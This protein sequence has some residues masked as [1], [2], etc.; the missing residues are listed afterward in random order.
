MNP[1]KM[2]LM[3]ACL[4]AG[5]HAFA[6]APSE[7]DASRGELLYSTHCVSCHTAQ[8]HW[9]DN[10]LATDWTSL[11]AQ[12]NRW[13]ANAGLGWRDA[14]IV[15]VARYLNEL[16]YHFPQTGDQVGTARERERPAVEARFE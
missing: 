2:A 14:D 3:T 15:A 1:S 5:A 12:V 10:R 9:R 16:H 11:K 8:I 13:Q 6:Q 7:A 4:A